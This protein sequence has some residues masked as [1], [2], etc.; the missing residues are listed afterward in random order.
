MKG[1][2]GGKGE[3][4]KKKR[5]KGS[6]GKERAKGQHLHLS[7]R[8]NYYFVKKNSLGGLCTITSASEFT[9]FSYIEEVINQ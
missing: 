1:G 9:L 2:I 5:G 3:V 6:R 7:R 4:G 8:L